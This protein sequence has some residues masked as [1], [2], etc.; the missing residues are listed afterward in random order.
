[1]TNKLNWKNIISTTFDNY[2]NLKDS[3]ESNNLVICL[4]IND[5]KVKS[6]F[7]SLFQFENESK[8]C[9]NYYYSDNSN[10]ISFLD[11]PQLDFDD[12]KRLNESVVSLLSTSLIV[13]KNNSNLNRKCYLFLIV[14]F[15]KIESNSNSFKD[16]M[17]YLNKI[18]KFLRSFEY[19]NNLIE[20]F[21]NENVVLVAINNPY[22][23]DIIYLKSIITKLKDKL[24]E[25]SD[26]SKLFGKMECF[27]KL[28]RVIILKN[29]IGSD[30][31]PNI[32]IKNEN[33]H[34][35]Y[36]KLFELMAINSKQSRSIN[37]KFNNSSLQF[38]LNMYLESL[39]YEQID[40]IK[41]RSN[42]SSIIDDINFRLRM[43][44]TDIDYYLFQEKLNNYVD[45]HLIDLKNEKENLL[46]QKSINESQLLKLDYTLKSNMNFY[47]FM[48]DLVNIFQIS[49]SERD[50]D[51]IL[52]QFIDA[53]KHNSLIF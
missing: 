9:K 49:N 31:L 19:V 40:E 22:H 32:D 42:L 35:I 18:N 34:L 29:F 48:I 37:I 50:D 6:N 43:I 52:K 15:M 36:E 21:D 39:I 27:F 30:S 7:T 23:V 53:L 10:K 26:Y 1:M 44:K 4:D 5:F 3:I 45:P 33:I 11:L 13:K 25:K 17:K 51:F 8:L 24:N 47:T 41:S 38:D 16:I 12:T 20:Q 28:N 14:D 46:E 2:L